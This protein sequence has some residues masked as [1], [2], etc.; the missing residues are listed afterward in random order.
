[1]G[2]KDIE[3]AE[4]RWQ[5]AFNGGDAS[6]VAVTYTDN[7]RLLAPGMDI[8]QGRAAIEEFCKGFIATGAQ[9]KFDLIDVRETGDIA[10]AVGKYHMTI[11]GAPDDDG[12]YIEVWQRQSDG[13]WQ[14]VDDIFNSSVAP[15]A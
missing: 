2:K 10:I 4:A 12:K 6:G 5:E 14:I 3:A 13:N 7:A 1:M 11:P 15:P 8:I 9:L